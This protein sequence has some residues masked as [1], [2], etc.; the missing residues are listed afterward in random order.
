[1]TAAHHPFLIFLPLLIVV[2][3][4]I[5]LCHNTDGSRT[6]LLPCLCNGNTTDPSSLDPSS[7]EITCRHD[8]SLCH[9]KMD[10]LQPDKELQE[11]TCTS[12]VHSHLYDELI[13]N[14]QCQNKIEFSLIASSSE[15]KLAATAMGWNVNYVRSTL[16]KNQPFKPP[17]CY[18]QGRDVFFNKIA[19]VAASTFINV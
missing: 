15:C 4:A 11:G 5:D 19:T 8:Q 18:Q 12:P 13:T 16:T 6:N 3:R 7:T 9:I 14:H 1:M 10:P 17:G 2:V